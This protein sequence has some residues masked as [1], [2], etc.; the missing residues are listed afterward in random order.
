M[1]ENKAWS[2]FVYV[3]VVHVIGLR[4]LA[5][6]VRVIAGSSGLCL[7]NYDTSGSASIFCLLL[8]FLILK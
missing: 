6:Q 4:L 5:C 2:V 1:S 7:H 3:S 8:S